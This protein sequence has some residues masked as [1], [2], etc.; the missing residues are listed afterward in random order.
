V[1]VFLVVY[2]DKENGST[3]EDT[4]ICT[5]IRK[6]LFIIF[7][8]DSVVNPLLLT[9]WISPKGSLCLLL[10]VIGMAYVDAGIGTF[11]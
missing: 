7:L 4:G 5:V 9:H 6:I 3:I 11:I 8:Q 2:M 10:V 1:N